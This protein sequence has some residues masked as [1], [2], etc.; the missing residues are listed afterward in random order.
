M[1]EQWGFALDCPLT[2]IKNIGRP[3][4]TFTRT[5][6]LV[7]FCRR[8]KL[9]VL[10]AGIPQHF[11]GPRREHSRKPDEFFRRAE[12]YAAGPRLDMFAGAER[13][14]W[15]AWGTPPREG[16]RAA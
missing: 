10:Q 13:P 14:G 6:E 16:E 2:W 7:L 12:L 15:D 9:A 1:V 11:T 4:P 5:T 8:G 3:T